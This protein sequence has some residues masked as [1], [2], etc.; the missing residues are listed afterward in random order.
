MLAF[1]IVLFGILTRVFVHLPNFT[2]VI[3]IALFGGA[4]LNKRLAIVVPLAIF[5]V[6]DMIIGFHDTMFF[7]WGAMLVVTGVG[8]LLRQRKTG[9]NVT[10][11]AILSSVLFFG[12]SNFGVWATGSLGYPMTWTGLLECYI[13][14]LP[15]FPNTLMS[16]LLYALVLFSVYEVVA[17]RLK[18]TKLAVVL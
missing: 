13:M 16:T 3:A 8:I 18:K 2:P 9:M 4:Y 7:T 5:A 6:S 15:F 17:Y 12:I 11:S 1:I 14:A 10:F